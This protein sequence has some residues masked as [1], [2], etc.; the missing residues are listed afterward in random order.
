MSQRIVCL[1]RTRPAV[2]TFNAAIVAYAVNRFPWLGSLA[3]IESAS[4]RHFN[5]ALS[6]REPTAV[7]RRAS[8]TR[9]LYRNEH[10]PW[11][12]ASGHRR[13]ECD[14]SGAQQINQSQLDFLLGVAARGGR[15]F[16]QSH[17]YMSLDSTA[18]PGT[19]N[20]LQLPQLNN[21]ISM[22]TY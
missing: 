17:R 16:G 2:S 12:A 15:E 21:H 20:G 1:E 11:Q 4:S 10:V 19:N 7:T 3:I 6:R 18:V 5:D 13:L 14:R 8:A 9:N 22:I